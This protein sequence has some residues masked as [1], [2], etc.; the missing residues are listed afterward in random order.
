M[1][2][3]TSELILC[4]SLAVSS[5]LFREI[6]H[7]AGWSCSDPAQGFLCPRM[8]LEVAVLLCDLTVLVVKGSQ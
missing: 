2:G 4:F 8:S 5:L 6:R 7:S 1:R 3:G